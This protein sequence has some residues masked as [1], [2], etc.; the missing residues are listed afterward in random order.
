MLS[1]ST[2]RSTNIAAIACHSMTKWTFAHNQVKTVSS[3]QT[4]AVGWGLSLVS[5]ALY[6][7]PIVL[8]NVGAE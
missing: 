6:S 1:V 3:T 4:R 8:L 5:E 7:R 2:R